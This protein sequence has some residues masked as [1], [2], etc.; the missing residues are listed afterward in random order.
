MTAD[1]ADPRWQRLP[2]Y[3]GGLMGPFGTIVILPMFPELRESFDASSA[4]VSWGFTIYLL[5]FAA[6]L[7]VSG[8][9]GERWGRRRTV[10]GTY[11]LYAIASAGCAL[12]PNL[13]MFL[14]ARAVQGVANAFITPL[15]VAGLAEVVAPE[16]FGRAVGVYSSFQAAGGALAPV[17][18]GLA[19]DTNW[20]WAFVGTGLMATVLATV[21]PQGKPVADVGAASRPSFRELLTRPMIILGVGVLAAAAGPIGI[22]VLV[23]VTARDDLG[24]TGGEAGLVLLAGPVMAML[25]GPLWG[26]LVDRFGPRTSGLASASAATVV[27]ALLAFADTPVTLAIMSGISGALI[28]FV[29][30][31]I[32]A[33]ASTIVPGNRGGALSFILAFRFFGHGIGPVLWIPVLER[34]VQRAFF[35]AAS[36][37]IITLVA[38][39]IVIEPRRSTSVTPI[40]DPIGRD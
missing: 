18:G 39:F 29:A 19:A 28:G 7:L 24:L 14:G 1:A 21:P 6:V 36:L 38:F 10:R 20:R 23:G 17:I 4:A 33:L 31:V 26:R 8:T 34:S 3:L 11:L 32:Q 12:A 5:P 16:L 25:T 13:W 22:N 15:L 9:L 37:G 35:G 40:P 30:V 2:L 27:A